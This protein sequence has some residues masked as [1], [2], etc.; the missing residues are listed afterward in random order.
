[1][2]TLGSDFDTLLNVV[3]D[4]CVAPSEVACANDT[5]PTLQ[6]KVAVPVVAGVSYLLHVQQ[7]GTPD[8]DNTLHV[9]THLVTGGQP[10]SISNAVASLTELNAPICDFLDGSRFRVDFDYTDVDGDILTAMNIL[11]AKA[12]A[13]VTLHFTPSNAVG[14]FPAPLASVTGDGFSGTASVDLCLAFNA[15]TAVEVSVALR[16]SAGPSKPVKSKISRPPGAH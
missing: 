12:T 13:D 4:D 10:P 11:A 8:A 5:P 9:H 2:D 3:T 16:D 6:S 1:V 14:S 7:T 15:D